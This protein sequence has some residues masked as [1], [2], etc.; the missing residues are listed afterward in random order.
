[1]SELEVSILS[2]LKGDITSARVARINGIPFYSE[3]AINDLKSEIFL[4]QR[5]NQEYRKALE[6]IHELAQEGPLVISIAQEA[7]RALVG[8]NDGERIHQIL[9]EIIKEEEEKQ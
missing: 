9:K 5:A 2:I 6:K 1:M 4:L 8:L 7:E 3:Q